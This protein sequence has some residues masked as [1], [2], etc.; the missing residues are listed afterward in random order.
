M[1]KRDCA[2]CNVRLLDAAGVPVTGQENDLPVFFDV[3]AGRI[4]GVGNGD[5]NG[6]YPERGKTIPTFSGRCQAILGPDADG[7][8]AVT[9]RAAGL[10]EVFFET[11]IPEKEA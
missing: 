11:A 10:P 7:R 3:K 5:P 8:V 9:V 2:I 1:E 4:L 6:V